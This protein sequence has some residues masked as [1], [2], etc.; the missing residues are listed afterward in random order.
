MCTPDTLQREG[1]GCA[2]TKFEITTELT[3][4]R[5]QIVFNLN[6]V[7]SLEEVVRIHK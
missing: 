5:L 2:F 7:E 6:L 1:V 3:Y 4:Y